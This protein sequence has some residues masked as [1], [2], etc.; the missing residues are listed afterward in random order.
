MSTLQGILDVENQ[1]EAT[2]G[3]A[4]VPYVQTLNRRSQS[5]AGSM[6]GAT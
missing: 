6:G 5:P 1:A 2:V 3:S 4:N